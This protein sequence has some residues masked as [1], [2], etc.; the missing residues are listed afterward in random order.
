MATTVIEKGQP[1]SRAI[2][3]D[4]FL[5]HKLHSLTGVLPI[6]FFLIFHLVVNSYALRGEAEFNAGAKAIS[7]LPFVAIVEWAAIFIPLIFHSV[8]GFM[9]TAEMRQNTGTYQYGR[10]WLYTLQRW[11]GVV[12]FGYVLYHTFGTTGLRYSYE[13][14]GGATGHEQGFRAISYAAMVYRLANPGVLLLYI[15]GITSAVFHLANGLFN[16]CIRWGITVGAQ[17]QKISAAVWMLVGAGLTGIGL[18]T[19]FNYYAVGQNFDGRGPIRAQ[20]ATLDDLVKSDRGTPVEAAP[21]AT[22]NGTEAVPGGAQ[23]PAPTAPTTAAP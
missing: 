5:L 9:I 22:P 15:L 17:A 11:S 2:F 1:G 19:A 12:A 13:L 20:Y 8:Y 14:T 16:F 10:N 4:S 3:R 21:G 18:W 23:A 6:G 7:Y